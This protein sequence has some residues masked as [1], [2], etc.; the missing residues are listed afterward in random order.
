M[1]PVV[2]RDKLELVDDNEKL[3]ESVERVV[4]GGCALASRLGRLET[5]G[6]ESSTVENNLD[7][8]SGEELEGTSDVEID[9]DSGAPPSPLHIYPPIPLSLVTAFVVLIGTYTVVGDDW[10]K[11]LTLTSVP[12]PEIEMSPVATVSE[13]RS[14]VEVNQG[15]GPSGA[16]VYGTSAVT[17]KGKNA[18]VVEFATVVATVEL[19]VD[20]AECAEVSR[21]STV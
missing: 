7:V 9:V 17:V 6:S 13:P 19:V 18:F 3:D 15:S 12:L 21:G 4:I 8:D 1:V 2:K 16:G 10:Y 11:V 20:E 14:V 5:D